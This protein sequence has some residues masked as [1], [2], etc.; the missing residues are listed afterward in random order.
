MS[1]LLA[2]VR[3]W[4]GATLKSVL[5]PLVRR[6]RVLAARLD[7]GGAAEAGYAARTASGLRAALAAAEVT[8][9]EQA[10][11]LDHLRVEVAELR[12][13][14]SQLRDDLDGRR[15]TTSPG[16]ADAGATPPA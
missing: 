3:R 9:A 13:E 12:R 2:Q 10:D 5:R 8:V 1:E 14:L 7:L 15:S 6:V 11:A 4:L 16:S